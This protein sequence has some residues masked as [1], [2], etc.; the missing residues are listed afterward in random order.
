MKHTITT[1]VRVTSFGDYV[2]IVKFIPLWYK[3]TDAHSCAGRLLRNLSRVRQLRRLG[4]DRAKIEAAARE[5]VQMKE[6]DNASS[7]H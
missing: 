4:I 7:G 1:G 2:R 6:C 5:R 3:A